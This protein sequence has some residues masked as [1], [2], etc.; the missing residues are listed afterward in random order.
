MSGLLAQFIAALAPSAAGHAANS[1]AADTLNVAATAA[2]IRSLAEIPM[3]GTH[4]MLLILPLCLSIAIVYKTLRC[5]NLRDIPAAAAI[6]WGTIVVGM[7]A[8][9]VGLWALFSLMV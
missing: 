4:H 8:V 9:G 7:Y 5:E 2:P 1:H 6:L 3:S